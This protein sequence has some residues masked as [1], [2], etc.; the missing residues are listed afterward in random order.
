M[1]FN[2][3]ENSIKMKY[4]GFMIELFHGSNVEVSNPQ[5]INSN[6]NLDFGKG[7]Y[8]T[9]N[10][11]QAE[12]FAQRICDLREAGNSIVNVY[13]FDEKAAVRELKVLRFK[14]PNGAWLDFVADNRTG[15]RL[16]NDF[17]LIVGPVANDDVFRTVNIYLSGTI[18][19]SETLKRLKVKKLFNQYVFCS[20]KALTYLNFNTS[21]IV[22]EK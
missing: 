16:V 7:F 13:L 14:K 12:Q 21:Y 8:T 3:N 1:G 2:I 15:K 22:E 6:R 10:K 4:N 17:D 19:R 9:T 11:V 5:I 20:D 18:T